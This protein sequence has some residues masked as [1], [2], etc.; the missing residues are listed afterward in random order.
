MEADGCAVYTDAVA[1]TILHPRETIGD[2][3]R[4]DGLAFPES[5]IEHA[6]F[7]SIVGQYVLYFLGLAPI[8]P[9]LTAGPVVALAAVRIFRGRMVPHWLAML[10]FGCMAGVLLEMLA[11]FWLKGVGGWYVPGWLL[12]FGLAAFLP[13]AG[14]LVRPAVVFSAI[15]VLGV[16]TLIYAGLAGSAVAA[17]FDPQYPSPI[18]A[19]RMIDPAFNVVRLTQPKEIAGTENR[20][21]A[22]TPFPTSAGAMACVFGLLTLGQRRSWW[23]A[24]A[25]AGWLALIVLAVARTAMIAGALGGALY[26]L[27]RLRRRHLFLAGGGALLLLAAFAGPILHGADSAYHF[28]R[29]RRPSSSQDRTNLRNLAWEGWRYGDDPVLGAGVSV[30]GGPIVRDVSIGTHDTLGANFFMRGALG[31]GLTMLPVVVTLVFGFFAGRSP[32]ERI[33]TAVCAALLVYTYS[34]EWQT[35][36]VHIWPAF[37]IVGAITPRPRNPEPIAP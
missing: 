17:G 28:V 7:W 29:D 27:L 31:F 15:T 12:T 6:V 35:L 26:F 18:P 23:K 11:V 22:F 33:V 34:Q 36:Y 8:A 5:P 37:L 20:L 3:P 2:A 13:M 30:R 10:W 21:I 9:L 25:L 32:E 4:S 19:V 1:A 24:V 14:P 16:Q